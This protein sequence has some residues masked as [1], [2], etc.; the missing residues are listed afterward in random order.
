M[1][2]DAEINSGHPYRNELECDHAVDLYLVPQLIHSQYILITHFP[3]YDLGFI[4]NRDRILS[5]GNKK[6]QQVIIENSSNIILY[7]YGHLH[8]QVY[9]QHFFQINALNPGCLPIRKYAI[10]LLA[11]TDKWIVKEVLLKSIDLNE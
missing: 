7:I 2:E 3:P 6:L 11:Y 9:D 4:N 8:N 5:T 10:A 1:Y